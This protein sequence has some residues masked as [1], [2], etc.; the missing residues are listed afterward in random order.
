MIATLLLI[1]NLTTGA[2]DVR[3]F[4]DPVSCYQ[5]VQ[6]NQNQ[7]RY[8]LEC[9]PAGDTIVNNT[10]QNFY[11]TARVLNLFQGLVRKINNE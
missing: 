4:S 11:S 2:V 8:S 9:V 1:T 5:Y 3:S 10:T 6:R 7:D